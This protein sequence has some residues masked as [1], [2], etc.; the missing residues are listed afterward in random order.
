[1][2]PG[3]TARTCPD[4]PAFILE[5]SGEIVTH[6]ELDARSN[7]TAQLLWSLVHTTPEPTA[8][9]TALGA[10]ALPSEGL[11]RSSLPA[12]SPAAAAASG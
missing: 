5:P 7:R 8:A 12:P 10:I 3:E 1:M 4:R 2:Y 11:A 9:L 6:A